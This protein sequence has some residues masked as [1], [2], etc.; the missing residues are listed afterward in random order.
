MSVLIVPATLAASRKGQK[1]ANKVE[2]G[3]PLYERVGVPD[4]RAAFIH[5]FDAEEEAYILANIAGQP[6][7]A[8]LTGDNLPPDWRP[9]LPGYATQ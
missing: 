8:Y 1:M 4:R 2:L 3:D 6:G 7:F 9:V 5:A